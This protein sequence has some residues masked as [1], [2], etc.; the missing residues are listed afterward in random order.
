[1]TDKFKKIDDLNKTLENINKIVYTTFNDIENYPTQQKV[2]EAC[3]FVNNK[4]NPILNE[5]REELIKVLH[6]AYL[7]SN[8]VITLLKPLV[9]FDLNIDTVVEAVK[10]IINIL[11]GPYKIAVEYIT[12]LA[13]KLQDLMVNIALLAYI[14]ENIPQRPDINYDK[15]KISM[16]PITINEIITGNTEEDDTEN[17]DADVKIKRQVTFKSYNDLLASSTEYLKN[18]DFSF[19]VYKFKKPLPEGS[20]TRNKYEF[21]NN[22]WYPK[23]E[24]YDTK[25]KMLQDFEVGNVYRTSDSSFVLCTD[26][27]K[28]MVDSKYV[29]IDVEYESLEL[30]DFEMNPPVFVDIS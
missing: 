24:I 19:V 7:S 2:D 11:A 16:K 15:L 10:K 14:P 6:E 26:V 9:E 22:T 5:K 3:E 30:I 4:T 13:P 8:E 12:V 18:G 28:K 17:P 23:F 27:I 1:M 21:K 29:T 20:F 25:D